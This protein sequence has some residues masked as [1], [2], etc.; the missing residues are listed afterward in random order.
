MQ[1]EPPPLSR[2]RPRMRVAATMVVAGVLVAG[3]ACDRQP[4]PPPAEPAESAASQPQLPPEMPRPTT[5]ELLSGEQVRTPLRVIPFS[6]EAPRGWS[7]V[8]RSGLTIFEGPTPAGTAQIHVSRRS[9]PMPEHSERLMAGA[10]REVETNPGPDN[11]ANVRT[12][13]DVK[14]LE[15]RMVEKTRSQPTIDST[16]RRIADTATPMRWKLMAFVPNAKDFD[17]CELTFVGLTREQY[18]LDKTLLQRIFDSLA[19]DT[20]VKRD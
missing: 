2:T 9:S 15:H 14:V 3:S 17:I 20:S 5:Q 11:F 16:G 12:V 8:P 1:I 7:L 10:K 13:G 18:D 4:E 19:Y 6:L